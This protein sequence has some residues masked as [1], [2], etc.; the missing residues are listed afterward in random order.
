[1]QLF[2]E[3]KKLRADRREQQTLQMAIN[4]DQ[5]LAMARFLHQQTTFQCLNTDV[6]VLSLLLLHKLDLYL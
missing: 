6:Q 3:L 1:M 4:A 5:N 2:V